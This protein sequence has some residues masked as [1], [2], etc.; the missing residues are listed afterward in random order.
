MKKAL[1]ILLALFM[2][3]V[4]FAE[5]PVANLELVK[6]GGEASVLFGADLDTG[7]AAFGNEAKVKLDL[8]L[9]GKGD[10]STAGEGV[11]GELVVK[12]DGDEIRWHLDGDSETAAASQS[13][14]LKVD[15][16]KLHFPNGYINIKKGD[17]K[18][19]FVQLAD[20]AQPYWTVKKGEYYGAKDAMWLGDSLGGVDP[21]AAYGITFGYEL[22]DVAAFDVDFRS[23]TQLQ[24]GGATVE[25]VTNDDGIKENAFGLKAKVGLKAVENL[26]LDAAVNTGFGGKD[27]IYDMGVGAKV[28]YKVA[29]DDTYYVKPNVAFNGVIDNAAGGAVG[30]DDGTGDFSYAVHAGVLLGWG[31]KG[32]SA[33]MYFVGDE[34][35]DWGYYPGVSAGILMKGED[36]DGVTGDAEMGLNVSFNAGSLIENLTAAAALEIKDLQADD[37]V[38]GFMG[39]LKYKVVSGDQN[40]IPKFGINYFS[41]AAKDDEAATDMYVKAGVDIENIFPNCTL[42]FEYASNDLNG[43]AADVT[44]GAVTEDT[45]GLFYTKFKIAL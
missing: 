16:A 15:V 14:K 10:K 31:D 35:K 12:T 24:T 38:M 22:P 29:L 40:I 11:W 36:Y 19:D 25:Q 44:D 2:V 30:T 9:L 27:A 34:D 18:V 33:N 3:G 39:V 13:Y 21:G 28:A 6:F 45:M 1:V 42:S 17:A 26:T 7:S 32:K 23:I 4:V 41:N 8:N 37:M 5:E 20:M 43:G